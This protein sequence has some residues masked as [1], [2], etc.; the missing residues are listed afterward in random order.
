[1]QTKLTLRLEKSLI[2]RAKKFAHEHDT[3]LSRIVSNHFSQIIVQED[4]ASTDDEEWRK[5]LPPITRSLLGIA[6]GTDLD[7]QDYWN[8]L[9]E[10]YR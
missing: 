4:E 7:E 5:S 2:E 9:E 3:S 8:Y 10:K 1:M 6:A